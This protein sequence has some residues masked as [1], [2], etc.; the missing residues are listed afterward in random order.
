M[1][2]EKFLKEFFLPHRPFDYLLFSA[3]SIMISEMN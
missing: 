1:G 2:E 3:I